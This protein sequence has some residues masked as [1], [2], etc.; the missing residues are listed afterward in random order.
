MSKYPIIIFEGIE[1]SG[2]TT[3]FKIAANYL[4]KMGWQKDGPCFY[5]IELNENNLYIDFSKKRINLFNE[6]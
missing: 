2:K 6:A 4:K 3:N 1:A 5:K